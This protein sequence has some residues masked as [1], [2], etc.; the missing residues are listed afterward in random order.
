LT[1]LRYTAPRKDT[2]LFDNAVARSREQIRNKY[3]NPGNVFSDTV[4]NVLSNYHYRLSP[5]TQER[6]DSV[7]LEKAYE[8]YKDRF[9][10][11][12]DA[13]FVFVGNFQP[14]SIA[15]LLATYLGALPALNRHEQPVILHSSVPK[16]KLIKTVEKGQDNKA[17]VLLVYHG[18]CKYSEVESMQLQALGEI[19]QYRLLTSL[20]ESAGEVYTPSVQASMTREPDPRFSVNIS[21]GCAPE[22]VEHLVGLVQQDIAHLQKDGA[23]ADEL[24]KYKAGLRQQVELQV[25]S[26]EFWLQ[27]ISAKVE[28]KEELKPL[29]DLEKQLKKIT[30]SSISKATRQYL[31]GENCIRFVALPEKK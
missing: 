13:N 30:G 9:A 17:T 14:D 16:G 18:D 2:V 26:N 31:S 7:S 22:H 1:Y 23:T 8:I 6:L 11:A 10:D 24:Q 5:I 25:K 12:A 27:Y 19:L 15:P 21:F 3:D 20:R 4:T 29:P 28:R